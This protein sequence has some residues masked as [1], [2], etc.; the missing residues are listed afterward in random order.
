MKITLSVYRVVLF[1]LSA[2]WFH[3]TFCSS[4]VTWIVSHLHLTSEDWSET[5]TSWQHSGP[6]HLEAFFLRPRSLILRTAAL[7]LNFSFC[8]CSLLLPEKLHLS[9]E[10]K[11]SHSFP[12]QL[13]SLT[14]WGSGRTSSALFVLNISSFDITD[15]L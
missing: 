13:L 8:L 10:S 4:S 12:F 3:S 9:S 2:P 1:S 15:C 6:K 14:G 5:W 7:S 11:P